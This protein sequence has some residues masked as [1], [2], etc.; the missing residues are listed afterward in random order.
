MKVARAFAEAT[1]ELDDAMLLVTPSGEVVAANRA[2][3]AAFELGSRQV[4]AR[5][6]DLVQNDTGRLT[7]FLRRCSGSKEPT[8]SVLTLCTRD[9]CGTRDFRCDGALYRPE[10]DEP[11]LLRLRLRP[12]DGASQSF[13][14]L[15]RQLDELNREIDLRKRNAAELNEALRAQNLLLRELQ[16]RVRNTIQLFLSLLNREGRRAGRGAVDLRALAAR[17][18]AVGFVQKQVGSASDLSRVEV[19]Q[20]VRDIVGHWHPP[21]GSDAAFP[22][23]VEPVELPIETATPLALLLNECLARSGPRTAPT[24][25]DRVE[26]RRISPERFVLSVMLSGAADSLP[27]LVRD[28]F[29]AMLAIQLD[30]SMTCDFDGS[31]P[32][33]SIELPIPANRQAG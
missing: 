9:G 15:T 33:L 30:G 1:S 19:S 20:L 25:G 26:G 24:T 28:Q 32:R 6:G 23:D 11:P 16:H 29:M 14:L 3:Q 4:P 2:A 12:K 13:A 31:M 7:D 21:L 5:L 22:V 8:P 17:F 10:P 18:H 27:A